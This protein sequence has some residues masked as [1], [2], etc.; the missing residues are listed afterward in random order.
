MQGFVSWLVL[1]KNEPV[2]YIIYDKEQIL[3]D[4]DI[5]SLNE[6]IVCRSRN[7]RIRL[8]ELGHARVELS[9]YLDHVNAAQ[10]TTFVCSHP[11]HEYEAWIYA[12]TIRT[13][14]VSIRS[15]ITRFI[16]N[17]DYEWLSFV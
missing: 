5:S 15:R 2:L 12:L 9:W 1:V 8:H 4:R 17:G 11:L 13:L 14:L 16:E 3:N 10:K 7:R 6:W